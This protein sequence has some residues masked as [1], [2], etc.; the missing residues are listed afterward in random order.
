MAHMLWDTYFK[1]ILPSVTY[2]IAVWGGC[3]NSEGFK[4]LESLHCRSG[5]IIFNMPCDKYS[6]NEVGLTIHDI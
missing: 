4:S 1:I 3:T 6:N 2:A 5:K